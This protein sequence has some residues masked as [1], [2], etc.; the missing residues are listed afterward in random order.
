MRV[1]I[2]QAFGSATLVPPLLS[3]VMKIRE[4]AKKHKEQIQSHQLDV[5]DKSNT[6]PSRVVVRETHYTTRSFSIFFL[7]VIPLE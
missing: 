1:A 4:N 7:F 5:L 6:K 2:C 3:R